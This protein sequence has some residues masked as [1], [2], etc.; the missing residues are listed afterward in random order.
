MWIILL[1]NSVMGKPSNQERLIADAYFPSDNQ[2]KSWIS[3]HQ[4]QLNSLFRAC[5]SRSSVEKKTLCPYSCRRNELESWCPFNPSWR[6]KS[7]DLYNILAKRHL[8]ELKNEFVKV[9]QMF[10]VGIDPIWMIPQ[11]KISSKLSF[12][13]GIILQLLL[14]VKEHATILY[15]LI[16]IKCL[17]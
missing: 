13:S 3:W 15:T 14:K 17:F 5:Q 11:R 1:K 16:W 10:Y 8:L 9:F 4:S 7:V 12:P 6:I 2:R